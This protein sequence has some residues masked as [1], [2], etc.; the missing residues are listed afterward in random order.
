M[1]RSDNKSLTALVE[2]LA[3]NNG[4]PLSRK[5]LVDRVGE[6]GIV[7]R[8]AA[9][10]A[11]GKHENTLRLMGVTIIDVPPGDKVY[12]YNP[13]TAE[14]NSA[15]VMAKTAGILGLGNE[16]DAIVLRNIRDV[17]NAVCSIKGITLEEYAKTYLKH[18]FMRFPDFSDPAVVESFV[19]GMTSDS[20]TAIKQSVGFQIAFSRSESND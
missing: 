19:R 1:A 9:Y 18:G 15:K 14:A 12:T 11:L 6:S 2:I 7:S 17:M 3:G 5:D 10:R 16:V 20:A 13:E 8:A 4:K